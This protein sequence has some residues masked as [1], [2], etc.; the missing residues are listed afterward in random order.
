M[1]HPGLVIQS[2]YH[3]QAKG[4]KKGW[5]LKFS[6]RVLCKEC[7]SLEEPS[8][9]EGQSQSRLPHSPPSLSFLLGHTYLKEEGRGVPLM[10]LISVSFLRQT[11]V[12]KELKEQMVKNWRNYPIASN[13]V[14]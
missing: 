13:S 5:L 2:C 11:R 12:E 10:L 1:Q 14:S 9:V 4:T 8:A 6:R 3:F 7:S